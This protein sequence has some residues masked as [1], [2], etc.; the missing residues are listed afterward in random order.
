MRQIDPGGIT[1]RRITVEGEGLADFERLLAVGE[2]PHPQLRSLE[3]GQD[4]DRPP[5]TLLD[6]ANPLY[7]RAH[8]LMVGMA[9]IDA[10]SVGTCLEEFLQHGLVGGGGTDRGE[11]LDL[12]AASH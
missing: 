10:E 12:A 3:I 4:A 7:Q 2:F 9:H 6:R 8:E 11:D 5:D 1:G